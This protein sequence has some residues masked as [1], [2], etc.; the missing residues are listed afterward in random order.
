VRFP[1][2]ARAYRSYPFELSGGLRQ[3]AMIAMALV[4]G[5]ALLIADEPTTALDVTVQAQILALI[6]DLQNDLDMAVLMITHDMG[7]VANVAEEVVVIYRGEVME[8]GMLDDVIAHPGHEYL[9]ALMR[10]VPKIDAGKG[11]RLKP[12]CDIKPVIGHLLAEDS[13]R[14]RQTSSVQPVILE[15]RNLTKHFTIRNK[16]SWLGRDSDQSLTAVDAVNFEI[17]RGEC[18]GLV[19]ESGCGKTTISKL[20]MGAM[21]ADEGEIF[22]HDGATSTDLA[23]LDDRAMTPFRKRIQ[24]IFQDPFG[25]LNPRMTTYDILSEPLEIHTAGDRTYRR[26]MVKELMQLVGLDPRFL[27]RYP[28]SFSGGQ[29]QRIG[30]A[31]ALV[32]RPELI[33]CDEPVSALDVSTQ[34]QVL[35]LLKDLQE[36]LALTFLFISH[37]LAVVNYIADRIAVMCNGKLVE[38]GPGEAIFGDPRHPYTKSL[39]ASVPTPDLNRKLD[40][41]AISKGLMTDPGE[42]PAPFASD[43]SGRLSMI[44]IGNGHAVRAAE[45][46]PP[47]DAA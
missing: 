43:G 45:A 33:I 24:Y 29:R 22:F 21:A 25:S 27:N 41:D 3:R 30:I 15:V 10:A 26:G 17:R 31:R 13:A 47:G 5:P 42:W 20:I 39:L 7:V 32:L 46:P 12:L 14:N 1:D 16:G 2:P 38:I 28:H 18:L 19:G 34:A 40:F 11:E 37:D 6:R 35:N 9:Q 36:K 44:D 4:C 8:A 23:K